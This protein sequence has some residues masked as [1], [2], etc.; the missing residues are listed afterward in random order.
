MPAQSAETSVRTGVLTCD[1]NSGWGFVFGSTR[2]LRCTYTD[3]NGSVEQYT[4]HIDKLGVDIGY[5]AGGVMA[6]AVLAPTTSVGSGALAGAYGG[7]TAG[8][9]VGVGASANVLVGSDSGQT[10]SLQPLSLEG[11]TG[12]D[13]AAGVAQIVLTRSNS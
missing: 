3:N 13:V 4:G 7:V 9:A 1:V 2:D 8:V 12:V 6:W 5:H 11:M 10:I